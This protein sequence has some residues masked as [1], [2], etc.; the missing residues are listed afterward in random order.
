L[1][2]T[3]IEGELQEVEIEWLHVEGICE[4]NSEKELLRIRVSGITD[5]LDDYGYFDLFQLCKNLLNDKITGNEIVYLPLEEIPAG[6]GVEIPVF[7]A[8]VEAQIA[9]A[10]L[11]PKQTITGSDTNYMQL[12]LVNK[13]TGAVICTKTFIAGVDAPAYEVT[14]F[15]PVNETAGA[16]SIGKG[17]SLIK[18]EVGGGMALPQSVLVIQ[19][20][21][22]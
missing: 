7:G 12:K 6:Q 2:F 18:E 8:V 4:V 9:A 17:V 5:G 1:A 14:D 15:G 3:W 19:W 21:L 22:R 16:V 11:V 13:E 10:H 20:N